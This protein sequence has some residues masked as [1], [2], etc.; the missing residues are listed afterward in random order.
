MLALVDTEALL[1]TVAAS[2]VAGVGTITIFAVAIY[3]ATRFV[4]FSR[5]ERFVAAAA[6][7]TLAVVGLLAFF[8]AVTVGIVVMADK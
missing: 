6:A 2:A 1:E 4:D 3:G 7:A 5:D 8:A